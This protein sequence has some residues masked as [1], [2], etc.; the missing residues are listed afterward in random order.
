[1]TTPCVVCRAPIPDDAGRGVCL[2]CLEGRPG[3]TRPV[4]NGVEVTVYVARRASRMR[5]RCREILAALPA[6][7]AVVVA[8]TGQPAVVVAACLA[9][10]ARDARVIEVDGLW[11]RTQAGDDVLAGRMRTSIRREPLDVKR[12][13]QR[14]YRER[15]AGV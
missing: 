3:P 2:G 8:V 9:V 12:L 1:M 5:N 6:T 11:T 14:R 10:L 4:H 7:S 15:K 13:R